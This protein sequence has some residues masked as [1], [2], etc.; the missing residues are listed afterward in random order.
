MRLRSGRLA[1]AAI[2]ILGSSRGIAQE[3][4][5]EVTEIEA[6]PAVAEP[7]DLRVLR[8]QFEQRRATALQPVA[9]RHRIQVRNAFETLLRGNRPRDALA[10]QRY[11]DAI[12]RGEAPPPPSDGEPR[13]LQAVRT[14]FAIQSANAVRSLES[15]YR[16]Q[17]A[18][19]QRRFT[20]AGR[21]SDAEA[22][23]RE[24]ERISPPAPAPTPRFDWAKERPR[25]AYTYSSEEFAKGTWEYADRE[26][27]KLLDGKVSRSVTGDSVGWR[28]VDSPAIHVTFGQP[29]Q[30]RVF[31][32]AVLHAPSGAVLAP[33]SIVVREGGAQRRGARLGQ[34][35][36][37]PPASDWIEVPLDLKAPL[38]HFAIELTPGGADAFLLIEEIEFR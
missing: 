7:E 4:I 24:V 32:I 23:R 10:V 16:F 35:R 38:Q 31:R 2:A 12:E 6:S 3:W 15:A 36:E 20:A 17:L 30:P 22:V 13:E 8:G 19:L 11:L 29:V 27:R 33:K 1:L 21:L 9:E 25:V 26:R 5:R 28:G 14:E 18:E 37:V 34:T